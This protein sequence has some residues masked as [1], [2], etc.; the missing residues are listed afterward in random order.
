[1]RNPVSE[2]YVNR[3]RFENDRFAEHWD[4]LNVLKIFQHMGATPMDGGAAR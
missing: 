4:E 1:M 3:W 2:N